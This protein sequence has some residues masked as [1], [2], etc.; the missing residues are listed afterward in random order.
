MLGL[1]CG[2]TSLASSLL[3][4][5]PPLMGLAQHLRA[6]CPQ[7]ALCV[8]ESS[9][10]CGSPRPSDAAEAASPLG[11]C[12]QASAGAGLF[13]PDSARKQLL[14]PR[15]PGQGHHHHPCSAPVS[16]RWPITQGV[17]GSPGGLVCAWG[18]DGGSRRLVCG[19]APRGSPPD[20]GHT[21]RQEQGGRRSAQWPNSLNQ[22]FKKSGSHSRCDPICP[23]RKGHL[24]LS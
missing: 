13:C 23:A 17:R 10:V 4:A 20:A 24:R 5:T 15:G 21:G 9:G 19:S 12:V 18:V 16:G 8:G 14:C 2:I 3:P 22:S 7:G 6:M 1:A 11:C